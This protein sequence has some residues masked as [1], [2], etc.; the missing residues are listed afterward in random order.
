MS[1]LTIMHALISVRNIMFLQNSLLFLFVLNV[2]GLISKCFFSKWL[3][4]SSLSYGYL[5]AVWLSHCSMVI[6]LR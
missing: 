5:T 2:D 4:R 3:L 6:S 1:F